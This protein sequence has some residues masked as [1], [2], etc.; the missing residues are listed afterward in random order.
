LSSELTRKG[1]EF[2]ESLDKFAGL[3]RKWIVKV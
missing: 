2:I 1:I 3:N